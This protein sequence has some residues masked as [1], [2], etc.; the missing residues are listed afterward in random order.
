M[1][2]AHCRCAIE[3]FDVTSQVLKSF[4]DDGIVVGSQGR[5]MAASNQRGTPRPQSPTIRDLFREIDR[6]REIV[7]EHFLRR[8]VAH[9]EALRN[10]EPESVPSARDWSVRAEQGEGGTQPST[11]HGRSSTGRTG[12]VACLA[13]AE[14]ATTRGAEQGRIRD[15]NDALVMFHASL[16]V[17]CV[18]HHTAIG[19]TQCQT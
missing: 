14:T 8:Q 12:A 9:D 7:E 11:V 13:Y 17:A 18:F 2:N 4:V 19:G 1:T 5:A 10:R 6:R 3:R 15:A 16:A